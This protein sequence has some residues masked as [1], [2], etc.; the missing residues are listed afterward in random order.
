MPV[1]PGPFLSAGY[2][3]GAR[4]IGDL[5]AHCRDRLGVTSPSARHMVESLMAASGDF[6]VIATRYDRIDHSSAAGACLIVDVAAS[7]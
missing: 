3:T 6:R 4:S 7:T 1:M 2:V 5:T